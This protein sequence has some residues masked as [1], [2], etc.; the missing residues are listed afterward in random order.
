M[1]FDRTN[2]ST[3]S[4]GQGGG[5]P[6]LLTYV[7]TAD[8]KATVAAADYFLGAYDVITAKDVILCNCSDGAVIAVI[9]ASSSSTVT[10]EALETIGGVS[11]SFI[12]DAAAST[13]TVTNGIITAIV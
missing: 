3:S 4:I 2:L 11:G 9:T 1:A 10:S 5:T 8:A 13:I 6:G 12:S 7:T